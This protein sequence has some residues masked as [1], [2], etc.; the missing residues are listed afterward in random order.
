MIH[1]RLFCIIRLALVK[2][3][4]KIISKHKKSHSKGT[5]IA[6]GFIKSSIDGS[7]RA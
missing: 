2:I 3:M 7:L 1:G 4:I 5:F 6:L